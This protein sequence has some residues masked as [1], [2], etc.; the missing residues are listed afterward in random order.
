MKERYS[1]DP[2]LVND[3]DMGKKMQYFG[4]TTIYEDNAGGDP[5]N[6]N[7]GFIVEPLCPKLFGQAK[8][9]K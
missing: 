9:D 7:A 2:S 6:N 4:D 1:D 3:E 8:V 5:T